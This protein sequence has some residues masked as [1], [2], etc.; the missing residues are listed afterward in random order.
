MSSFLDQMAV[1][2]RRRAELLRAGSAM[3]DLYRRAMEAEA[4]PLLELSQQGFDLIAEIE[5]ALRPVLQKAPDAAPWLFAVQRHFRTQSSRATIDALLEF[6]LRT[7]LSERS[8]RKRPVVKSQPLWL[9]AAFHALCNKGSNYQVGI[10]AIFPYR[11]KSSIS[12]ESAV[13]MIANTWLACRPVLQAA[14]GH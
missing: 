10:G 6:N 5:L 13:D 3:D 4:A 7:A 8:R 1:S 11:S 9:K 12:D 2:S 14:L